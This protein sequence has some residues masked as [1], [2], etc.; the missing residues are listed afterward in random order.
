[1]KDFI[2]NESTF[3]ILDVLIGSVV[4]FLGILTYGKTKRI[5]YLFFVIAALFLYILM[6]FRV[7][8]KLNI[9]VLSEYT[10]NNVGVLQHIINYLPF[11]FMLIGFVI[12]L[13]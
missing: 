13:R 7:V 2:F 12:L 1:M 6:I 11:I 8:E 3:I 10:I 5:E 4:A 9:F